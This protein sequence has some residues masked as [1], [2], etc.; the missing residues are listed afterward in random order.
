MPAGVLEY[1]PDYL[2]SE[3]QTALLA[4]TVES[5]PE[6]APLVVNEYII[7]H[8]CEALEDGNPLYLD[9]AFARAQG[10]PRVVAPPGAIM[11]ALTMPFRWPWPPNGTVGPGGREPMPHIHYLVKEALGLPVGI[12][13]DI[14]IEY[15]ERPLIGDRISVSQRLVSVWPW[16]KTKVGE[17]HFW[18]MERTYRNQHEQVLARETMTAFGYG[19]DERQTD[20]RTSGQTGGGGWSAA[21]EE[22]IEGE[23]TGYQPPPVRE[24]FWEDVSVGEELPRLVMPFTVTRSVYLASATRDFSPQHSNR[25]YAQER[26]KT[27]DVFVN[28][29]FNV[30][31]I[32]RFLTDW[33]GPT[34]TVRRVRFAMKGNVCA[35]DDM[36]IDGRVTERVV[37]EGEHRVVV[38]VT[39]STQDG[40]VT[41]CT[42]VVALPSRGSS[43]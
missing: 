26:S 37:E 43:A 18:T 17:G 38:E 12:I 2:S 41:P 33:A 40:P 22:M 3:A 42:A 5:E 16:K 15:G 31:M 19:R 24:V 21:V 36:I 7:R 27:A 10:L 23:R 11:T 8:W 28:T 9:E 29:P 20:K 32:S 13:T 35:G 14:D 30:G 39:I 1:V 34:A 6:P 4:L 25:R